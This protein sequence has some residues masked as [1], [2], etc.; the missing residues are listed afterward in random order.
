ML[1]DCHIHSNFSCDADKTESNSVDSICSIAVECGFDAIAITDHFET[2]L[3]FDGF[4]PMLDFDGVREAVM[5]AKVK[6]DGELDVIY[7]IEFAQ[8]LHM[9]EKSEEILDKY[10]FDFVLG[11]V[12]AIYGMTDFF[13]AEYDKLSD[14]ELLK[15]FDTYLKEQYEMIEWGRFNSLAHITYPDRY[16]SGAGKGALLNMQEREIEYFDAALK[17]IIKKDI[18]LELNTSGLRK[19]LGRTLPDEKLL[20]YYRQLGGKLVTV[21]SDSHRAED[22]GKNIKDAHTML[23]DCGFNS[24]V[25]YKNGKAIEGALEC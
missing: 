1:C 3:M 18:A 14:S 16:Y 4:E 10:N 19:A 13:H 25:Y 23:R 15:M 5:E 11:S 8:A 21:G 17:L 2:D 22:L 7:G 20:K 9:K 24:T 6:Y 12:H